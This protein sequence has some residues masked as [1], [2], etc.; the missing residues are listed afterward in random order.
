MNSKQILD[1]LSNHLKNALARAIGFATSLKHTE[2]TPLHLLLSVLQEKG[3]LGAEILLKLKFDEKNLI[4][5]LENHKTIPKETLA[6]GSSAT[7]TLAE[8]SNQSK[9][10]LE[11]SMLL[12][13]EYEQNYVG[14]E[15]LLYGLLHT[16]DKELEKIFTQMELEH[17]T[18]E[19]EIIHILESA[20][21]FPNVE[22]ISSI[23]EEMTDP[24]ETNPPLVI[25]PPPAP[26]ETEQKSKTKQSNKP[27]VLDL[28]TV[29]LTA[30]K[31]QKNIDPVIGRADE[32]ERVIHILS[33]R[34]KNN[35]VLVGEPGVG[36]TAIVE[37]LAK[38]IVEGQ[39]PDALQGKRILSLDL[40]LLISGTIY[41][42]E[43]EARLRQIIEEISKHP[44]YILFIDE[45]HNIIGAGSN[46][47][48]MDA[49]NILKPALAR[50]KLRCIGATTLDEYKKYISGD[51]ALE[52]R[53]QSV[54]IEEPSREDTIKI[55]KGIAPLYEK[56]HEVKIPT[57]LLETIVELSMKFVHDNFL[58]DKAIDILDE[59]AAAVK[60]NS[61]THPLKTKYHELEKS[62]AEAREK[63]QDCI[64]NEAFEEAKK[65]K[66]KEEKL[67]KEI[68]TLKKKLE[69]IKPQKRREVT[70]EDV[71]L[72]LSRKLHTDKN[73][74]LEN[75]YT[76]LQ[77][78][79]ETLKKQIIGQDTA[80]DQVVETLQRSYLGLQ[81]KKRPFASL[82]FVGPSGVG[83]TEL[84][85][86]LARELYR[87][88]KALIKMDMSEFAEQHGVSK[89]LGSP[90][91]YIGY[92]ERNHFA[93]NLRKRP[94]SVVLFDEIDK[95][96]G[97]VMKLLLQILDEGELTESNGKKIIFRHAV[98]ILTSNVGA[99]LF[100]HSGIGFGS[101][102]LAG[103]TTDKEL[104]IQS[105]LKDN[106]G[107][108]LLGRL[109]SICLFAPLQKNHLEEIIK[110]QIEQ[111]SNQMKEQFHLSIAPDEKAISEI[112]KKL[113]TDMGARSVHFTLERIL[114]PLLFEQHKQIQQK[115]KLKLTF[116]KDTFSLV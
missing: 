10:A 35:P 97:D 20:N 109:G 45:I 108:P 28:F 1:N 80:I 64:L 102:A 37:G 39:V 107:A 76:R 72:I 24:G 8:L 106:F 6:P 50:G 25:A 88:E 36:K 4:T 78:L 13:Y 29:D 95:A 14:T 43:F 74:F 52:R 7:A 30:K 34:T 71:A 110:K 63:K 27:T 69:K 93:E 91:G 103:I 42:G 94:Y 57:D 49:A 105:A 89:L 31:E 18:L 47:G 77:N 61:P 41:R 113:S 67:V 65:W 40:T 17:E 83:K 68:T 81:D 16:H 44:E 56:Y 62:L 22:D 33:R 101:N 54:Q 46:Q 73:I 15:H 26:P 3:S 79:K 12:A 96:H 38:R 66:S 58:P 55:L 87:D 111:L 60:V 2:V 23:L 11:K 9:K 99:E 84:A 32:I 19:D 21:K 100:K 82:L 51:P 115:K 104:A 90:A 112:V 86:I 59:A 53:F 98:I 70:K 5:I 48:T 116:E 85:K 92:K 75:E 114:F